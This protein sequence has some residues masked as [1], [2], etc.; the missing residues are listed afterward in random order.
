MLQLVDTMPEESLL[1]VSNQPIAIDW[2]SKQ[3]FPARVFRRRDSGG[4]LS[5]RPV[6]RWQA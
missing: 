1:K 2:G 6:N 3:A 5:Q 4:E